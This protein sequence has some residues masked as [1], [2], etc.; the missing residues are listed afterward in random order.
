M[1]LF[2]TAS[3][4]SLL[5]RLLTLRDTPIPGFDHTRLTY[6]L[7]GAQFPPHRPAGNVVQQLLA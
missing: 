3:R 2:G 5:P 6:R 1:R 4:I 7:Q